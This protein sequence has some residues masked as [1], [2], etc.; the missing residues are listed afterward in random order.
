MLKVLGSVMILSGGFLARWVQLAGRKQRRE[1]LAGLLSA[2]R[3][4]GEE[5]R[6]ARTPLPVLLE[7]AAADRGGDADTLFLAAAEAVK[8][9]EPLEDAW[10]HA[11]MALPLSN[12]ERRITAELGKGLHGDEESVCKAI[13]LAIYE[14][15]KCASELDASRRFDDQRTTALCFSA[16][17]LLVILLI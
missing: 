3:R 7:Q 6:M 2:L 15:A 17:A 5:I 11:A 13:S 1:T 9:G 8:A 4:M 14:L 16:S 10:R 12:A